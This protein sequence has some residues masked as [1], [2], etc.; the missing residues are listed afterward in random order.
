MELKQ[1]EAKL[2]HMLENADE[3]K[4]K[5]LRHLVDVYSNMKAKQAAQVLESLDESIA[6][7]ILA[8]MRGR[9]AGEILTFVNPEKAALLSEA[10][11]KM[12]LP[13]Q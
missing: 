7:R 10:L 12:Q 1:L 2:E 11:T 5:K 4:D 9:Q 3:I 13:F 8:G 6:V